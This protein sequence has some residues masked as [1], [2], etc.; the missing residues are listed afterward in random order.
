M[1]SV[2]TVKDVISTYLHCV[3]YPAGVEPAT[4]GWIARQ[5]LKAVLE[6][7]TNNAKVITNKR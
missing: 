4:Y 3:A 7:V 2:Q 1:C 6:T 5:G